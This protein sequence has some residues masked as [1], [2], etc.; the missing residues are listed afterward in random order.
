MNSYLVYQPLIGQQQT[1][2]LKLQPSSKPEAGLEACLEIICLGGRPVYQALSYCWGNVISTET[3]RIEGTEL[4]ITENLDSALRHLRRT[5]ETVTLWIDALCI[6]QT[7]IQE[8]SRQ[9]A[10]MDVVYKSATSVLVWLGPQSDDSD[11]ALDTIQTWAHEFLTEKNHNYL[12][13]QSRAGGLEVSSWTAV[14]NLLDR[15][16]W[17]RTWIYQEIMLGQNVIVQCGHRKLDW[18]SFGALDEAFY[19]LTRKEELMKRELPEDQHKLKIQ[20]EHRIIRMALFFR[21]DVVETDKELLSELLRWSSDMNCQDPRDRIYAMLG[22][23][24]ERQHYPKP[25]YA[26]HPVTVYTDFAKAQVIQSNSLAI[27]HDRACRTRTDPTPIHNRLLPTWV[28]NWTQKAELQHPFTM[29]NPLYFNAA[30][31]LT[32]KAKEI[33]HRHT[34]HL[35]VPGIPLTRITRIAPSS[36]PAMG[37]PHTMEVIENL[38]YPRE[39]GGYV[40]LK[41]YHH[42]YPTGEPLMFALLRMCVLDIDFR[43][44]TRLGVSTQD[45]ILLKDIAQGFLMRLGLDYGLLLPPNPSPEYMD[46]LLDKKL[47]PFDLDFEFLPRELADKIEVTPMG[48]WGNFK[49][50]LER[51]GDQE[52][53][54][55]PGRLLDILSIQF[56]RHLGQLAGGRRLFMCQSGHFGVATAEGIEEGDWVVVLGGC[57]TPVILREV[58]RGNGEGT[59]EF[60]SDAFVHGFMDGEA[61]LGLKVSGSDLKVREFTIV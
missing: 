46:D 31:G 42:T 28:P 40:S 43:L 3:I 49:Q 17:S 56:D 27:L 47:P 12:F 51:G 26:I 33:F 44:G 36:I 24:N 11:L 34:A 29:G 41:Q 61:V 32:F 58:E 6:N 16:Y 39:E 30:A 2:V 45:V 59:Y 54:W 8:R 20:V 35:T 23:I 9:V 5:D 48:S 10:M 55:G 21:D 13:Q 37:L 22:F 18:K 4:P 1:R 52:G 38:E 7:D 25:D 53:G 19:Q 60:V 15:E 57:G 50:F 14:R